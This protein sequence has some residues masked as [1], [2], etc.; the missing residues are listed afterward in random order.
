MK[1]SNSR[2][3]TLQDCPRYFYL[4]YIEGIPTPPS[5]PAEIGSACHECCERALTHCQAN[6]IDGDVLFVEETAR[7]IASQMPPEQAADVVDLMED[8]ADRFRFNPDQIIGIEVELAVGWDGNNIDLREQSIADV[9]GFRG[10]LDLVLAEPTAGGG[11]KLIIIDW[12]FGWV[13]PVVRTDPATG[14]SVLGADHQLMRYCWLALQE[15][16]HVEEIELRLEFIRLDRRYTFE[17]DMKI[18]ERETWPNILATKE[19]L[20]DRI[21][22]DW[23][24]KFP[25]QSSRRCGDC[26]FECPLKTAPLEMRVPA[27]RDDAVRVAEEVVAYE[28]AI[29]SRKQS[30]QF[31]LENNER[32]LEAAG[33][34]WS[35]E[36][37][38][39]T[40][41]NWKTVYAE[42]KRLGMDIDH[43]L[44]PPTDAELNRFLRKQESG[45]LK[46]AAI[47]AGAGPIPKYGPPK[48]DGRRRRPKSWDDEDNN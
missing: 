28:S 21:S 16:P 35:T 48:F 24:K 33:R 23:E 37:T 32:R 36:S 42:A 9:D 17:P 25:P 31:Y 2:L 6:G 40:L 4:A 1:L 43:L 11:T 3:E 30:L 15:W 22:G 13:P 26:P 19:S 8:W 27:D 41:W 45:A 5:P 34:Y 39:T 44:R 38:E 14:R 10:K 18:L 29:A 20:E 12:K 46:M 7:E 47:E